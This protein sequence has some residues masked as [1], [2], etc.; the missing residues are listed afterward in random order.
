M[1][2]QFDSAD[3]VPS[4]RED[5]E[6]EYKDLT[7]GLDDDI[8]EAREVGERAA[9]LLGRSLPGK[10]DLAGWTALVTDGKNL[11]EDL[12]SQCEIIEE[13]RTRIS[14]AAETAKEA[15]EEARRAVEKDLAKIE[16]AVSFDRN[17]LNEWLGSAI[18]SYLGPKA[19]VIFNR[20]NALRSPSGEE[21]RESR[22]KR[23]EKGRMKSGRIVSF[24]VRLPPRFSIG[25]MHFS[26]LGAELNGTNVGIDHDLAGA[27]SVLNLEISGMSG[28]EGSLAAD[29]TVDGRSGADRIIDGKAESSGW[30]WST[31]SG[32]DDLGGILEATADF[33]VNAENPDLFA[34]SGKAVISNWSGRLSGGTVDIVSADSPP[35]AV[36]YELIIEKGVPLLKLS[37]AE[38]MFEGWSK[39]LAE[40]ILP[41]GAEQAKAALLDAVGDDLD[42]LDEVLGNLN[43][44]SADLNDLGNLLDSQERKL[45]ENLQDWTNKAAGGMDIPGT[46][47]IAEKAA[48]GLKSLF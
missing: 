45:E 18:G 42:G 46:E 21:T 14:R 11:A 2:L 37:L 6:A 8:D 29:L 26:A 27:P 39:A 40:S 13:Y 43:A 35:L 23:S 24:P 31:G 22:T 1:N 44:E 17:T 19:E 12:K 38:G 4:L 36:E 34:A 5:L 33:F 10:N 28:V 15:S 3:L 30:A 47:D 32:E 48:K 16:D 20:I 9:E 25:K 41:L 7:D